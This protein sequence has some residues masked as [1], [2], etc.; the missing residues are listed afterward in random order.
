MNHLLCGETQELSYME[1]PGA[2]PLNLLQN[3]YDTDW[4]Q[5][6]HGHPAAGGMSLRYIVSGHRDTRASLSRVGEL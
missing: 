2:N 4:R 3:V 5:L 6:A 1:N